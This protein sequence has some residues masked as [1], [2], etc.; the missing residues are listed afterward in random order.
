MDENARL[1]SLSNTDH[2]ER[3]GHYWVE[4]HHPMEWR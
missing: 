3:Y 4:N 2:F 1:R